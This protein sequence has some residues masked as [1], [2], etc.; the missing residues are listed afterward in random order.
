MWICPSSPRAFRACMLFVVSTWLKIRVQHGMPTVHETL[1]SWWDITYYRK[2]S[3]GLTRWLSSLHYARQHTVE[4]LLCVEDLW[5]A[6]DFVMASGLCTLIYPDN[7]VVAFCQNIISTT[8]LTD[9]SC[10]IPA[11]LFVTQHLEEMIHKS[12]G[13]RMATDQKTFWY[14]HTRSTARKDRSVRVVLTHTH[15]LIAWARLS[16]ETLVLEISWPQ[17]VSC[18]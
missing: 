7:G 15:V 3:V 18:I 5:N 12:H 8:D 6:S 17:N 9:T 14:L 10:S 2:W 11:N 4:K 1:R 13:I 16:D